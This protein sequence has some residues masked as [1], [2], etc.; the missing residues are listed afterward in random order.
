M[1]RKILPN[2]DAFRQFTTTYAELYAIYLNDFLE[3]LATGVYKKTS[4]KLKI[5][6]DANGT[7][8]ITSLYKYCPLLCWQKNF[9]KM[10]LSFPGS[11]AKRPR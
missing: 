8:K 1:E 7:T 10:R 4:D 11:S 2:K 9:T 3:A 6:L 5:F